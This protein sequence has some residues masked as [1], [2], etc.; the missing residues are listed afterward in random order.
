[1]LNEDDLKRLEEAAK[2]RELKFPV[3]ISGID[4]KL[5]PPIKHDS[6][7]AKRRPVGTFVA[8]RSCKEGHGDKTYLGILVGWVPIH[9]SASFD[10]AT[11]RLT[12]MNTG[13]NPAIYVFDLRQVILGCESWWGPIKDEAHLKQITNDDISNVWYVKALKALSE[14][15]EESS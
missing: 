6:W 14:K 5:D 7:Q 9:A 12:F 15:S 3:E 11:K 4:F 13:E 1:M 10:K 8:I 2:A